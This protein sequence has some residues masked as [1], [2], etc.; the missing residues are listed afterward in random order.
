[1]VFL[2]QKACQNSH[3]SYHAVITI[4]VLKLDNHITS[5]YGADAVWT[6][7][8][9][10]KFAPVPELRKAGSMAVYGQS[11]IAH[12]TRTTADG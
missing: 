7:S 3:L 12:F 2:K 10:A 11:T 9:Q 8:Y 5:I 4:F 6:T 1:M